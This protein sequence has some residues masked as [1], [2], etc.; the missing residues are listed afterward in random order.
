[1]YDEQA[2]C[3][4]LTQLLSQL[5][6]H[7]DQFLLFEHSDAMHNGGKWKAELG[8]PLPEQGIGVE[9][10]IA[11]MGAHLIP[12]GSQIPNPGCTS[13]ITTG[14]TSIGVLAT[15]SGAVASPQRLGLTAFNFLEA[16]SLQWMAEMFELPSD[17]K[18]VYSSGGSVANLV[19]LG[20]ARQWVF[21]Q[22]GSDPARDGLQA[23]CRIYAS[24]ASHHTI[25]RS[26]AV[27]G[28][29]RNSVTAIP[30][31]KQGR[32]NLAALKQQLQADVNKSSV[33]VAIVANAGSTDTGAIDPLLEMGNLAREYKIWFH[34]D[35]AYG[36]PGILDPQVRPLYEGLSLADSVTVDPHKWLGAP[37]G[38]GA[39]Y[40]RDYGL[41]R[42][43][44]TQ[45]EASYLEGSCADDGDESSMGSLGIPYYD[46]GVELSAPSRG[47][48]VWALIREIGKSGLKDRIC[49]HNAMARQVAEQ[50]RLHPNLELVLEPTLSICCFRYVSDQWEDL[51]ELNRRIHRQLV[52]SGKNIPST[53][54]FDGTLAIRPCFVG[55]RTDWHH[56]RELV[57]EVI[58]IGAQ[59]LAK[60]STK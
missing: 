43:A 50:V 27:L 6:E 60:N 59:L 18:G 42:R 7:L 26:A 38:I 39:T 32:L 58:E 25:H 56:A 37:V 28:M 24:S 3:G 30:T 34:I 23:P 19:A 5:G 4:N 31:D 16:L 52:K 35:G 20:A 54:L 15:L 51:N 8:G 45:E 41:L 1:M 14:A 53:T 36:L 13:F 55:A 12:N 33:P 40:V 44:F 48:V 9:Q 17:M 2:E 21:E 47:A 29:G 10:V 57:D 11:E 46:F 22:R 49:R